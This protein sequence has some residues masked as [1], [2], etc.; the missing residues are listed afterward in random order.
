VPIGSVLQSKV[1]AKSETFLTILTK[2]T[3]AEG[4][5]TDT[6]KIAAQMNGDIRFNL[7]RLLSSAVNCPSIFDSTDELHET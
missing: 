2:R 4:G 5:V 1:Y 7:G 6:I 3:K